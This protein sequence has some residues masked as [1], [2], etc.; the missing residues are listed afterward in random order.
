MFSKAADVEIFISILAPVYFLSM[1][2][3]SFV[4]SEKQGRAY[5][6]IRSGPHR[7][8][9]APPRGVFPVVWFIL[10]TLAATGAY[11]VRKQPWIEG[12][13]RHNA[14]Y[15]QGVNLWPLVT[16]WILQGFLTLYMISF[17]GGNASEISFSRRLLAAFVVFVNLALAVIVAILFQALSVWAGVL[18]WL[19]VAWLLFAFILSIA[20]I[21]QGSKLAAEVFV[22]RLAVRGDEEVGQ[23]PKKSTGT[24]GKR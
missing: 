21:R 1:L 15:E 14:V 8:A 12:E 6:R 3:A 4:N 16:F 7:V 9:W 23:R 19:L 20:I 18:I 10:N 5:E 2:S 11:L 24:E 22:K 13:L 17:F